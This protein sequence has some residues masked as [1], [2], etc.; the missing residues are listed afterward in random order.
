MAIEAA[1]RFVELLRVADPAAT[2]PAENAAGLPDG[3]GDLHGEKP[4]GADQLDD[5]QI[6]H[7]AAE[8]RP[9]GQRR[10]GE[11][12]PDRQQQCLREDLGGLR[13]DQRRHALPVRQV[14]PQEPRLG[15]LAA[16]RGHG[17][18]RVDRVARAP[19][20]HETMEW[21]A[22]VRDRVSPAVAVDHH[23]ER[24][25]EADEDELPPCDALE[26][27]G[28]RLGAEMVDEREEAEASSDEQNC[29]QR[30][31]SVL[32]GGKERAGV[33][34]EE[35]RMSPR[36]VL[37]LGKRFI[38]EAFIEAARLEVEGVE[39]GTARLPGGGGPFVSASASVTTT[40]R[41]G[42][43]AIDGM[44]AVRSSS[45]SARRSCPMR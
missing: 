34:H 40:S 21:R 29:P 1:Q 25:G 8:H 5:Q 14:T 30:P 45:A 35:A 13:D 2:R 7:R 9:D 4:T 31:H 37:H 11:R 26:R 24:V 33:R 42:E 12:H 18:D 3:P 27:R 41:D 15:G 36:E 39:I 19:G 23:V 38:S 43:S 44:V 10:P 32:A 20:R 6:Q 28:D 22:V 16:D 17:G